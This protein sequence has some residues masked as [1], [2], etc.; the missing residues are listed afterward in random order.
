MYTMSDH[1][2][3]SIFA[4]DQSLIIEY[5]L[6][7]YL[8]EYFPPSVLGLELYVNCS[9]DMITTLIE[10]LL[11]CIATTLP[12]KTHW[13]AWGRIQTMLLR[14]KLGMQVYTCI[15]DPDQKC[16]RRDHHCRCL[17]ISS[18][19]IH[20]KTK[21]LKFPRALEKL[22]QFL[23]SWFEPSWFHAMSKR[24]ATVHEYAYVPV[25]E[26][27]STSLWFITSVT[28]IILWYDCD[29]KIHVSVSWHYE[30]NH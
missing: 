15:F 10:G 1:P 28:K 2:G 27:R 14:E 5:W 6:T 20:A 29:C 22:K 4:L 12:W 18:A 8:Y 23:S 11:I 13:I 26:Y 16:P 19:K 30:L 21:C 17:D 3:Y 25:L 24:C 7:G 9:I